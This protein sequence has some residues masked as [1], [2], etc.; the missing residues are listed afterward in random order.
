MAAERQSAMNLYRNL[1]PTK[2]AKWRWCGSAVALLAVCASSAHAQGILTV[3]PGSVAGTIAGTGTVGYTGNGAAAT[4]AT[5]ASPSAVT[6]DSLGNEYIADADNHAVRM[7]STTGIISTFAGSG[8]EGFSGD[9]GAATSAQLDTPTGVAVDTSGNVYIADSHNHCIRK[10]SGGTIS[11]IAGTGVAGFSGDGSAATGA[12]LSL[13]SAVAVDASG[14][15]YIADTNNHRI[16]KI[17][18]GTI[19]TIAG[20]G[21]EFFAGDGAA[22]TSAALDSPT[23]VAVDASGNVYI[24]DRLNQRIREVS[25]GT[26][27][28]LAGSGASSFA[29]GFS[30][31]GATPTASALSRPGGVSVDAAGNVYIVDSGNQRIRQIGGGVI[32]TTFGSASQGFGGDAGPATAA[33]LNAPRAVATDASGNLAIADRL[34]QRVRSGLLPSIAFGSYGVGL[35]SALQSITLAN[36]GTAVITVSTPTFLNAFAVAS[37]GTCSAPPITLAAGASCTQDIEFLPVAI[38]A[39]SGSVVFSGTGVVPQKI[40]LT[41]T[42]TQSST[43]TSLQSNVAAP[44]AGQAVTI[45]ATVHPAGA[46]MPLG[47]VSFYNNNVLLVANQAL[48]GGSVSLVTTALPD[49]ADNITAV[50]GGSTLYTGSTSGIA[51]EQVEDFQ[52]NLAALGSGLTVEPGH[53]VVYTFTLQPLNGAFNYPIILSATGL[54]PGATATF[55]P[56]TITLGSATTTTFT[57]TIQTVSMASMHRPGLATDATAALALLLLPFS[58]GSRRRRKSVRSFGKLFLG[59]LVLLCMAAPLIGCGTGSG[60]FGQSSQTYTPSV[61]GT[62]TGADAGTLQRSTTVTLTVE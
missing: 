12:Q 27:T 8:I 3:T 5:L 30:G 31:D 25:G 52:L 2:P 56:V 57:M 16:R 34:N 15:I 61:I 28:T 62:A 45:T 37:G 59:L 7:I 29:G 47:S 18:S 54:P 6:F 50:Y 36:T 40:L 41:G 9:G 26:I 33:M 4:S 13:P 1:S 17:T 43:T 46:G 10:V 48:S 22:A 32:A 19:T 20:D 55:N 60:L 58:L 49:G 21:D 14:N 39:G 11:T 44:L 53:A 23:G 24:A 35:P 51:A 42:G 38:G